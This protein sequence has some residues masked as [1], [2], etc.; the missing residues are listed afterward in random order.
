MW[1]ECDANS[2]AGVR[3]CGGLPWRDAVIRSCREKLIR[4]AVIKTD[5]SSGTSDGASGGAPPGFQVCPLPDEPPLTPDDPS[6]LR[7][8]RRELTSLD[9][10]T[11]AR[12]RSV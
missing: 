4:D 1:Q 5:G 3:Q 6:V 10:I 12:H 8:P 7:S 2:A 11:A 9:M